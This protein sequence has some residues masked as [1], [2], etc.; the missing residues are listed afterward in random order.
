MLKNTLQPLIGIR[1][2]IIFRALRLGIGWFSWPETKRHLR[3]YVKSSFTSFVFHSWY[4]ML[5]ILMLR[6][7]QNWLAAL[8]CPCFS[9]WLGSLLHFSLLQKFLMLVLHN[10]NPQF[11]CALYKFINSFR[12]SQCCENWPRCVSLDTLIS[13]WKL[14]CRILYRLS[15]LWVTF[16]DTG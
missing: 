14:G 16:T 5:N 3:K 9:F 4:Y 8:R 15:S 2:N 12:S 7:L 6:S 1:K 13:W 10:V 11:L